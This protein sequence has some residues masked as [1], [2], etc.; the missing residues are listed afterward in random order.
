MEKNQVERL[1]Y[2]VMEA[3]QSIGV[4]SRMLHDYIGDGS[5]AH[6][7]MGARVLIPADALKAFIEHRT[8]SGETLTK[9]GELS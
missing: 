5:I 3:A 9:K 6:F 1:A 8:R 4:S 7:R 2:S